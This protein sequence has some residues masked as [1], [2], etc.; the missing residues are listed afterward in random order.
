MKANMANKAFMQLPAIS[1]ERHRSFDTL[2]IR[3]LL[4]FAVYIGKI[5]STKCKSGEAK[6][7]PATEF[8]K[9]A[10]CGKAKPAAI[11]PF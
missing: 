10:K 5:A 8:L 3:I 9:R 1:C 2:L 11:L 4:S 7:R 6:F